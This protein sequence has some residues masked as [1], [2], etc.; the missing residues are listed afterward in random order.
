MLT[1]FSVRSPHC[2]CKPCDL[3]AANLRPTSM[4]VCGLQ[5]RSGQGLIA[6]WS[7]LWK[8]LFVR[9]RDG[10][11]TTYNPAKQNGDLAWVNAAEVGYPVS[12]YARMA[13]KHLE[14]PAGAT[15]TARAVAANLSQ[16]DCSRTVCPLAEEKALFAVLEEVQKVGESSLTLSVFALL[17][18]MGMSTALGAL[19][20]ALA[21]RVAQTSAS[22]ATQPLANSLVP[23]SEQ[24]R[25]IS[26]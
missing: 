19:A 21:M 10:M 2:R 4:C 7:E 1:N 25:Y 3:A 13:S 6:T 22:E 24:H 23:H 8:A 20:G 9:Y 18:A 5:V 11:V 26:F 12:W 15:P 14:A 17:V 16:A